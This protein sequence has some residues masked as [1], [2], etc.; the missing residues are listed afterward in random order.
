MSRKQYAMVIDLHK[1]VGCSA[2]DIACKAENNLPHSFAWSNH[3]LE[4]S[5]KFPDTRFRYVPT[6]CNHCE[7]APCVTNC[8]TTAMYKNEENGMTLHD[9]KKCIGCRACQVACPYGVI[10]FNKRKPHQSEN[11]TPIIPGCTSTAEE[12]AQD[13][14]TPI[15]IYNSNREATYP[16]VRPQGIVEKCT[17]CDHRVAC[18]EMPACVEACPAD[19]RIF[20]DKKDLDSP[21]S[22]A[23]RK[24][25]SRV[26]QPEKGTRPNVHYIRDY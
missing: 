4:T 5:G 19:A 23:L 13:R 14:G 12:V 25:A 22:I 3:I 24:Y 17:F 2:C 26:L 16:G 11:N 8:P 7:D 1:C 21:V 10:Y 6:L 15:P 9:P 18:G 20:G